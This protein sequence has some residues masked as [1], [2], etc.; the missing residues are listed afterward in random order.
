MD[1]PWSFYINKLYLWW[2]CHSISFI[3]TSWYT[4]YMIKRFTTFGGD[5]QPQLS[6]RH[7][8]EKIRSI[9]GKTLTFISNSVIVCFINPFQTHISLLQVLSSFLDR[10]SLI[11]TRTQRWTTCV[12]ISSSHF[13][14]TEWWW[15]WQKIILIFNILKNP[16]SLRVYVLIEFPWLLAQSIPDIT[17]LIWRSQSSHDI[18]HA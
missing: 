5:R 14:V 13:G 7:F 2:G 8:V 3:V 1:M 4:L 12:N 18:R 6:E 10:A 9:C 16:K 11:G 15:H 17:P